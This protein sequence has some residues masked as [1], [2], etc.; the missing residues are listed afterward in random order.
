MLHYQAKNVLSYKCI[1]STLLYC[2]QQATA[3]QNLVRVSAKNEMN[4]KAVCM[5]FVTVSAGSPH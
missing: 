1:S 2:C 3:K 4:L 5:L